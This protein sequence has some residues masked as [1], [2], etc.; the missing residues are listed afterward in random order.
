MG[1]S[2][3]KESGLMSDTKEWIGPVSNLAGFVLFWMQLW[4]LS[5]AAMS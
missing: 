3:Y 4:E 5:F 2:P 1:V